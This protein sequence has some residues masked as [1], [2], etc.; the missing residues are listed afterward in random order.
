M[1]IAADE[2][3]E[4]ILQLD[5]AI[6]SHEQWFKNLDR[7]LV[8]RAVNDERDLEQ[9]AHRHCQ[10]GQWYYQSSAQAIRALA[11]FDAMGDEHKRMHDLAASL[12][13]AV[14]G[15]GSVSAYDYDCFANSLERLRLQIQTLKRQ[16][17]E[18]LYNRDALTGAHSRLSLLTVLR[19]QHELL[20][21]SVQNACSI[22][23]MDLDNFKRVNDTFGHAAG[24]KT[25]ADC[26]RY[27]MAHCR[28]YDKFFRYGGEEFVLC[29]PG[30]APAEAFAIV[31]RLRIG[32]AGLA[33]VWRGKD[34]QITASFGIAPLNADH[35]VEQT[36]D[37]ADKALYA[38]KAA[39]RNSTFLWDAVPCTA[40]AEVSSKH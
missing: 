25:L 21:R 19:E 26:A 9:D 28:P 33:V 36:I 10:F 29:L 27:V 14:V 32:I 2:L 23:M 15:G 22:A 3:Q 34:I 12:L 16:L 39:G 6:Y 17:I 24:D 31:E 4:A 20:E 40:D 35:S 7:A 8:C 38:A 18:L 30:V 13:N 37:C 5:Q 11:G 1:H